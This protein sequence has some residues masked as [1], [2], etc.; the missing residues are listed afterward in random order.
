MEALTTRIDSQFKE[1]K[2]DMK[3]MRDGCNKCGGPHPSL[4]CDDKPMG[5]PRR[6]K[7]ILPAKDIEE[8][9]MVE[10]LEIGVIVNHTVVMKTE[11]QTLKQ[12][13]DP[14]VN[15]NAKPT[16]FLDESEDE[17]D[18]V[19][20]EAEPL[21][22]KP[23][24]VDPPALK[25]YKPKIP[26]MEQISDACLTEECSTILQNKL[27]PKLGDPKNPIPMG[28]AENMLVQVRK[29]VFYVD[30]VILQMEEDDRVPL[31]LGRPFLHTTDAIIRH[32]YLNDDTCFRMDVI[33]D[34]TEDELDALLDDSKPFLSTSKKISE[35][36]LDK[37]F[38]TGNVQEDEVKDDFKELPP[39]DELRIKTS[40][41][42]PPTDLEMKPLPKHMEYAFLEENSLL[43]VVIS[44]LLEQN[45]KER[46][47]SVLNNHKEAFTWKTSD[48]LGIS[49]SF[50][51]NKINFEDDVKPGAENVAA[52]HLSRL[53]KP[54]LKELRKEEINDEFPDK[55]LMSI[56]TDKKESPWFADFAN[57]LVG[58]IMRK[59][60]TYAQRYVFTVRKLENS[61]M[62]VIMDPLGDI[63]DLRLPQRKFLMLHFIGQPYSKKH[64]ISYKTVTPANVLPTKLQLA[65]LRTDFCMLHEL[66][67]LRLQAYENSKLY[68]ART[69]AYHDKKLKVRK[70]FK[71][72]DKVL[73]YNSKY[74]FKAPKLRSKCYGPFIVKHGYPFGYVKFYDKHGGSFIVNG[75]RVKLYHNKEQLNEL[76]TEE[77]HLMCEEERMKAIP[78]MALFLANYR[79]TM[80]W[81][82]TLVTKLS[83]ARLEILPPGRQCAARQTVCRLAEGRAALLLVPTFIYFTLE[84]T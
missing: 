21:P 74:K 81:A 11:A 22:K 57:Y 37:E 25:A 83:S 43:P 39:K 64:R 23:T 84:E 32:S 3:E 20:K 77:I 55:F 19:E 7:Q 2:G 9:I 13:Y 45:E 40:I 30:F 58:G 50:C 75:H 54:N 16:I 70:E 76:T 41:Q 14:L 78:F 46:L 28:V 33:D 10:I 62:N 29:F 68:K 59:G 66:D 38:M 69:K 1:I 5:G 63:M 60:L 34:V 71:A 52:N 53:E 80:P 48:I 61:S 67:E 12:D 26:K 47:I 31:I 73:L 6:K 42:D 17:A 8:I 24:H 4:D 65:P 72:R 18:E 36:P 35:T 27:P 82:K 51:K 44:A 79:E 15:P 49:P 56:S